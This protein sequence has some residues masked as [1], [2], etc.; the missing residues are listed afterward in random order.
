MSRFTF[1]IHDATPE[2]LSSVGLI[3]LTIQFDPQDYNKGG[4]HVFLATPEHAIAMGEQLMREGYRAQKMAALQ[5]QD[6]DLPEL[7]TLKEA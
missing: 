7:P 6:I 3:W 2:V 4:V 1:D 5:K